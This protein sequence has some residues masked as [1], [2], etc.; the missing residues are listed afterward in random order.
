[1]ENL[2]PLKRVPALIKFSQ[3]HHQG[4]LC[5]WK[6]REGFRK[7]VSAERIGLYAVHFFE[8]D[9][10]QHFRNEEEKLFI[11]LPADNDLRI[12][13][14]NDHKIIYG[15]IDSL[16]RTPGTKTLLE[17]FAETLEKH[18]RFEERQLFPFIQKSVPGKELEE[19]AAASGSGPVC[20]IPWDD[21]F[22]K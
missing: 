13:A 17:N 18:I 19:I 11:K 15:L 4:L 8:S 22:W 2:Q 1:M 20:E 10:K 7:S 14:E 9:L 21:A 5:V 6:I 12:E 16:R 3:E